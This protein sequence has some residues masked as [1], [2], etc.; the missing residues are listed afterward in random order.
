MLFICFGDNQSLFFLPPVDIIRPSL[1]VFQ[2]VCTNINYELKYCRE[3]SKLKH[4]T[5][6]T[7]PQAFLVSSYASQHFSPVPVI[8]GHQAC[9]LSCLCSPHSSLSGLPTL[10]YCLFGWG[11][12]LE[13]ILQGEPS[14]FSPLALA[15]MKRH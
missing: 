8:F 2:L 1:S 14:C 10:I 5:R 12:H 11:A 15:G 4:P 9:V 13:L 6:C 7:R 3:S